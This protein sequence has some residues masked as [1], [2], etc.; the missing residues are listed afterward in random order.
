M[1]NNLDTDFHKRLIDFIKNTNHIF[2]TT[3]TKVCYSII[4]R[5]HRRVLDGYGTKFGPI[6]VDQKTNLIVDGN[7]RYIAYKLAN[8]DFETIP[9]N[10]NYSDLYNNINDFIIVINEDWDMNSEKNRKYCSDD[11]LKDL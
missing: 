6:K 3:H 8:F 9:W 5:I 1:E 11:F 7:H 2:F 4:E 10:K